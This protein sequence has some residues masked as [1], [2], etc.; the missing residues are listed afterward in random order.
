MNR[1]IYLFISD[2]LENIE[3]IEKSLNKLN[4]TDLEKNSIMRDATIRRLEIIGEAV[5][6]IPSSFKI[7][8]QN[9]PWSKIAGFRDIVIHSYFRIDLDVTWN[10]IKKDLP[11]LKQN[12]LKIK[13]DLENNNYNGKRRTNNK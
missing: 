8:Y 10:I 6:N 11:G 7:K 1:S 3:L 2:I 5:K 4:K 13:N 12:I 9:V